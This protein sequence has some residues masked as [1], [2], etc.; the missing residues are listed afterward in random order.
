MST[1]PIKKFILRGAFTEKK[2]LVAVKTQLEL[3]IDE[4][5]TCMNSVC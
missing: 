3:G 2:S 4:E 1:I 5:K